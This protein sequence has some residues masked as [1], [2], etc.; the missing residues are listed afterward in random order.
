MKKTIRLTESELTNLIKRVIT[1]GAMED[2]NSAVNNQLKSPEQPISNN[3]NIQ[4]EPGNI[5]KVSPKNNPNSNL[6]FQVSFKGKNSFKLVK[7][8]LQGC[9]NSEGSQP[10]VVFDVK[11]GEFPLTRLI[12]M[13]PSLLA[14]VRRF[15]T[16]KIW[17]PRQNLMAQ[18][19]FFKK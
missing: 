15:W 8:D 11:N 5:L 6:K 2:V 14:Y 10:K 7:V 17:M 4:L 13:M 3:L 1:E 16:L 9:S 19:N 18:F 12:N